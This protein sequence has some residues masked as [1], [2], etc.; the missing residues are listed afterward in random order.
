MVESDVGYPLPGRVA[1]TQASANQF[2]LH[3]PSFLPRYVQIFHSVPAI[4]RRWAQLHWQT[5]EV[6][7]G[8]AYV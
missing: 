4:I 3:L 2:A 1:I 5:Q 6:G 7:T 8:G